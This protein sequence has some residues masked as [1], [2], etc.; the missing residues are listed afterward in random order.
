VKTISFV[1]FAAVPQRRGGRISYYELPYD[2]Q[3]RLEKLSSTTVQLRVYRSSTEV[4]RAEHTLPQLPHGITGGAFAYTPDT[5][6]EGFGPRHLQLVLLRKGEVL[7]K[8]KKL[9]LEVAPQS[10]LERIHF[11][12]A[13]LGALTAKVSFW[14]VLVVAAVVLFM[15]GLVPRW[16]KEVIDGR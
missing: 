8:S 15:L 4:F 3:N 9:I 13:A 7:T 12:L 10:F 2:L 6:A 5:Q 1:N 16:Q 11:A 14:P